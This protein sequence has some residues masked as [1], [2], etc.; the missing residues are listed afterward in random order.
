VPPRSTVVLSA[1][2]ETYPTQRDRH[3]QVIAGQNRIGWSRTSGYNARAEA[4]GAMSRYKHAGPTGIGLIS[5]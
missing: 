5:L 4:K 3:I 2:A 1:A